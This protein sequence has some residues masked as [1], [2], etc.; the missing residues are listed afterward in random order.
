MAFDPNRPYARKFT[1][2]VKHLEELKTELLRYEADCPCVPVRDRQ[3]NPN[4]RVWQY[5]AHFPKKPS[6]DLPFIIGDFVHN[7]RTALNYLAA[8]LAPPERKSDW[9][10]KF[11][12]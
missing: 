10:L 8:A 7:L 1:R 11:P 4:P 5:R 3:T 2:A 9:H 6:P 12:I